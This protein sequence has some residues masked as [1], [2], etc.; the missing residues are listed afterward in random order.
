MEP[1]TSSP[2][3]RLD[4]IRQ[5]SAAGVPTGVMVLPI[6]P[7]LN[8]SELPA[9]LKRAARSGPAHSRPVTCC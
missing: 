1:R 6:I 9:I 3:A 5:L 4:A 2:A 7:G 8:D